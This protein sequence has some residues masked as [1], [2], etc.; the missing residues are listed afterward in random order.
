M[1]IS[2]VEFV[3]QQEP[4][5]VGAVTDQSVT[6]AKESQFAIQLFQNNDYLAKIAFQNQTS[7]QNAIVNVAAI[8]ISLNPAQKLAY[9]VPRKGAICL[10]ISYMGLMHIAQ[11][12]GAIKWC[13]SA[14]VRRNDQF[15]REGLDKPPIHI[16]N[17]FDTEEQRGDIVGA[18]VTV[19]TD[20]GDYLTHTMRIDAIYSIRDRSEA[21]KKYKSDNSK[22]CPW[23]TDEEQMILK[24]VVKQAAKYWPR[25][26][27][28]D[29]AIDHVNTEG[30]EGINFAAERQ[31]ER[32]ITP[33]S[34][35]TQKEIND[36][37]VSLDKT[38]DADLLPLCSRIFKRPITQPADLAELEGV[39]AL[40]FL[41]QKAAA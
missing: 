26:D 11:Q 15:R 6:W 18:Y 20:D 13:Q 32:D 16:Y 23:V 8:G 37:L 24:T 28:L 2:I 35:T 40:G 29:A 1:S 7:T 14:I 22:K 31:P 9:L 21:W 34:E 38:W 10:D 4:L 3:K 5:F 25:R 12:S 39:K 19:K 33:L 27:R 41:R 36:L 17:D 30:E